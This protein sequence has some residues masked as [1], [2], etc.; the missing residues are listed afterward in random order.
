MKKQ[1]LILLFLS[2]LFVDLRASHTMGGEIQWECSGS[3]YIFTMRFYRDCSGIPWDFS[4]NQTIQIYGNPL[5]K[6]ATGNVVSSILLRPDS[7]EFINNNNGDTSPDCNTLRG[8]KLNCPNG[9]TP[10][11]NGLIQVFYFR[12]SAITLS[13]TPGNLGWDFRWQSVCC[14]PGDMDNVQFAGAGPLILRA[15][16]F[17]TKDR[18]DVNPCIDSSPDFSALPNSAVCRGQKFVY[19]PTAIDKDLDSLVYNWSFAVSPPIDAPVPIPYEAGFSSSNPTPDKTADIDNIPATLNA[20]TGVTEFLVTSGS[21]VEKFLLAYRVDSYRENKKI[22]SIYREFPLSVFNC[23]NFPN[24]NENKVPDV[25]FNGISSSEVIVDVVAGAGRVEIPVVVEDLDIASPPGPPLQTLT[26]VAEGLMFTKDK[27]EFGPG[28]SVSPCALVPPQKPGAPKDFEPCAF[29][30]KRAPTQVNGEATLQG[31]SGQISTKF[32]WEPDCKH[33]ALNTGKPG[34]NF[35]VFS[36]IFRVKDD[37]CPIPSI[38]YPT[39][40]VR[41]KDPFPL[42]EPIVKGV[43]VGLDGFITYQWAPPLDSSKTFE[44]YLVEV[45]ATTEGGTPNNFLTIEPALKK[46]RDREDFNNN[47]Y[48]YTTWRES[49]IAERVD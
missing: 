1:L 22:A 29:L 42:D 14:R 4:A 41:V 2:Y 12:S 34:T 39:I 19:N 45:A 17:P 27:A 23:P 25:R 35:G 7:T 30:E 46:Y 6:D 31:S 48:F 9:N 28:G 8:N 47:L 3:K 37:H 33:I 21:G 26:V 10:T 40:T 44:D 20:L 11:A 15:T 32:V 13:G 18:D 36:F 16:M 38:N 49:F 43:S 5:P 24:G